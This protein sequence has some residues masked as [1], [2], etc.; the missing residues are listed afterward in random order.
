MASFDPI[1]NSYDDLVA[2]SI[3]FGGQEHEY[4]TR[5]KAS[6]IVDVARRQLGDPLNVR[7]LDVGC[8]IGLT[9]E[10]LVGRIGH[11]Y[12]FDVAVEAIDRA[13]RRNP[14]VD[15][16]SG[17]G[18]PLPYADEEMDLAFAICVVHHIPPAEWERF[19]LE[20]R[21]VVRPGGLVALFEHNPLNPLT[22]VAVSRCAF[23]RDALLLRRRRAARILTGAGL[24]VVER[25]Y[26]LFFPFERRWTEPMERSLGWLPLG[27]QHYVVGRR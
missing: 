18:N 9:D 10:H 2:H 3:G 16:R 4:Y 21:R 27:A 14:T 25:R 22:R 23:D 5:R 1:A 15:Y 8:G 24:T 6:L 13:E 19:A 26:F 12:G 11:L 20:L 7:V 17:E